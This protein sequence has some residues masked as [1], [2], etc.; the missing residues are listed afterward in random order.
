M[1]RIDLLNISLVV[2]TVF[3]SGVLSATVYGAEHDFLKPNVVVVAHDDAF[4]P[5][6]WEEN[7]KSK[8]FNT[9]LVKTVLEKMGLKVEFQPM[10]WTF[11]L[12]SVKVRKADAIASVEITEDRKKSYD[13][14]EGYIPLVSTLF[15]KVED[16]PIQG[17]KDL[18]GKTVAVQKDSNNEIPYL[19][20]K[21]P[22]VQLYMTDSPL[23]ALEAVQDGKAVGCVIDLR[24]GQYL[25][26]QHFPGKFKKIGEEFG[27]TSL[28]VAVLKGT[29][30]EFLERFNQALSEIKADGTYNR[31]ITQWFK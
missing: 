24:V 30:T 27:K 8:G 15:V 29:K 7:G 23:G 3:L 31:I 4:P 9:D 6:E 18:G 25:I 26:H 5:Y 28:G 17:L 16:T 2:I 22:T 21:Y 20:E 11:A 12:T 14:T 1:K 13:L 19:R 10:S